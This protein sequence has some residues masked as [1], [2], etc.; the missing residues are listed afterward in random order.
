MLP[1][2]Q[3]SDK[4]VAEVVAQ[5]GVGRESFIGRDENRKQGVRDLRP[6]ATVFGVARGV[7]IAGFRDAEMVNYTSPCGGVQCSP[8]RKTRGRGLDL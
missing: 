8:R 7:G 1:D 4:T 2:C 5:N 6:R 3:H